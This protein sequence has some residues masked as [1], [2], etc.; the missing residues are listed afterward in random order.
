M[1]DGLH[2]VVDLVPFPV[3]L[4]G[5]AG[6]G[7]LVRQHLDVEAHLLVVPEAG[8]LVDVG[9][10]VLLD[11]VLPVLDLADLRRSQ[12]LVERRRV[13]GGVVAHLG[14]AVRAVDVLRV[15]DDPV[16]LRS[17]RVHVFRRGRPVHRREEVV[18]Q[19]EVIGVGP[20]VG[21]LRAAE[22]V[23][24]G[25]VRA[26]KDR[27]EP[28]HLPAVDGEDPRVEPVR[29]VVGLDVRRAVQRDRDG[30]ALR[31]QPVAHRGPVG[32]RVRPEIV[33]EG[34]V[35]LDDEHDVLQG[36]VRHG[37]PI[38]VVTSGAG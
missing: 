9:E 7:E 12:V 27:V 22:L 33:V 3:V 35:L 2:R 19:D 37:R 10:V 31:V 29:D 30:L 1:L 21:H 38:P 14:R 32:A 28:V 20:I 13:L 26:I 6:R 8:D 36:D 18:G 17:D 34:A 16:V 11:V 23:V 24:A 4:P 5:D 25:E 15:V